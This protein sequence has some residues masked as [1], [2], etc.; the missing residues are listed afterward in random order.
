MVPT[1]KMTH[2]H[3]NRYWTQKNQLEGQ[4]R[5]CQSL[6]YGTTLEVGDKSPVPDAENKEEKY[7]QK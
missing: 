4:Q 6:E 7:R 1:Q 2:Q 5:K 3:E